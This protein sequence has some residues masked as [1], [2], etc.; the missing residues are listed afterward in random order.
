MEIVLESS[1]VEKGEKTMLIPV[2]S[3]ATATMMIVAGKKSDSDI[4]VVGESRYSDVDN[5]K[6]WG[7]SDHEVG[8][9]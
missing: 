3:D 9:T 6:R 2:R 5:S 7:H 1:T 4:E 8:E